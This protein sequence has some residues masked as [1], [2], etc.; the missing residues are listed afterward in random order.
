MSFDS[1]ER[2]PRLVVDTNVV[3]SA[4][5]HPER[6]PAQALV[7]ARRCTILVDARIEAEYRSV[8]ARK[9]FASIPAADRDA[10][11]DSLLSR[12]E[13]V[14]T[15]AYATSMTDEDDRMF[16]EVALAGGADA[17][18]TGNTKH[19]PSTLPVEVIG[20]TELLRRLEG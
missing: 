18:I 14:V 11:L 4:L 19:F 8:L 2:A 17:I 5:L 13:R 7:A 1:N 9:K 20:P 10:L 3:V 15:I 16:V 6:T 12:A